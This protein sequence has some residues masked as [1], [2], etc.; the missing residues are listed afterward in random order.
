VQSLVHECSK[1]A[2][3]ARTCFHLKVSRSRVFLLCALAGAAVS[4]TGLLIDATG[5]FN[6]DSW[7]ESCTLSWAIFWVVLVLPWLVATLLLARSRSVT[8]LSC[9]LLGLSLSLGFGAWGVLSAA[10]NLDRDFAQDDLFEATFGAVAWLIL[11]TPIVSIATGVVGLVLQS[12]L[13]RMPVQKT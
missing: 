6:C 13:P 4:L 2:A 3:A 12:V 8:L 10:A 7:V 1:L 9:V 11:G 5:L